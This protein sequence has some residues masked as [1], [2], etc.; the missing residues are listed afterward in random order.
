M[1]SPIIPITRAKSEG[2]AVP[3][4]KPSV[5]GQ[6]CFIHMKSTFG[7]EFGIREMKLIRNG[8]QLLTIVK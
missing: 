5:D 3:L 7:R 2:A 8:E 4:E 1:T 6:I